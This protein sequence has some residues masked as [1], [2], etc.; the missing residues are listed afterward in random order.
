MKR[1]DE[2]VEWV[3]QNPRLCSKWVRLA[4]KRYE[5]DRK[6]EKEP[7]F[8]YRFDERKAQLFIA[9]TEMLKQY[10]DQ[11]AGQTL[12]LEPWQV[13]IF[14]NVYGWVHKDTGMRRFRKAFIFVARKNG[15]STMVSSVLIYDCMMTPGG[16]SYCAATK[17]DQSKIVWESV[18]QMVRQHQVLKDRLQVFKSTSTIVNNYNASKITALS[19]ESDKFD[20]LNP[21]ACTI[22]EVAAMR[23]YS[24][25][26]V[27]QSGTASRPEPLIF[28]ITS[29]S[30]NTNSA[31]A[32]EF[33]RS[34]KILEG[35]YDDETFFTI[36]YTLDKGDKWTDESKWIKANPNLG[37]SVKMETLRALCTEAQQNPSLEGEFRIKNLGM[38]ISPVTAWIPHDKWKK[39][40]SNASK[41][42]PFKDLPKR[43]CVAIGAID[44]SQRLDFTSFS[45]VAYH[46]PSGRFYARHWFYI[47]S[48]QIDDKCKTDSPL[49]RKWIEQ[50]YINATEGAVVDYAAMFKD[51]EHAIEEYNLKEVLYD[52]WNAGQLIEVIGPKVDLVE[53]KQSMQHIS[54]MA[55]DYE[56]AIVAG[57]IADD[58]PVMSWMISNADVYRDPNGNIKPV[59]HG[60]KT[61]TNPAHID[62]VVTSL[63]SLGRIKN[64]LD[65]GQIDLR[66]ASEIEADMTARLAL[67]DY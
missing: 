28:E 1:L 49:V 18:A 15:K 67:L 8:P 21:S 53:V 27:L 66:S 42:T 29:G 23:D 40:I 57:Q 47:P 19:S 52:P 34:Q 51:V 54:P 22:D 48:E 60:A 37:V 11:W 33:E 26:Q 36:L 31:G 55:K 61:S 46:I 62:G 63:M 30:D 10:K 38:F 14:A 2:Y 56:A 39:C 44:L 32:Q 35:V 20:G 65:N 41:F 5:N 58:N 50:G 45:V 16:E 7:D 4:I 43:E 25:I 24:I 13:F 6:R 12:H 59:K 9:F 64:L 17:R 3:K